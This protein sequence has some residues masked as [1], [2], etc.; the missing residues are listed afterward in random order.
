MVFTGSKQLFELT[1][2]PNSALLR[3]TGKEGAFPVHHVFGK[4]PLIRLAVSQVKPPVSLLGVVLQVALVLDP[5]VVDLVEVG[6]V[7]RTRELALLV[8]VDSSLAVE[9]IFPPLALVGHAPARVVEH[10]VTVHFVGEPL[11]VIVAAFFVEKFPPSFP[12]TV[13]LPALIP[14]ACPVVLNH[15]LRLIVGFDWG[16]IL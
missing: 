8:I 11:S 14:R 15:I 6:E 4:L 1:E 2:F 13:S 5:L 12:T 3:F 10:S 16:G 7:E 9:L